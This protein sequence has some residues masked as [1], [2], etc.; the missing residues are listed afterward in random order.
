[1]LSR[2]WIEV[3]LGALVRNASALA[4]HAGVPIIPMIKADA[5]GLGAVP[6]AHALEHLS[7]LAYGVAT[8]EEGAELRGAGIS[9]EIIIFTPLLEDDFARACELNITPTLGSNHEISAWRVYGTPYY[10]S[11]DTGMHRAGVPWREVSSLA[12]ALSANPP[13]GAFT[14]FHSPELDDPTMAQQLGRFEH[15]LKELPEIPAYIHTDSSAAIV[16]HSR[17]SRSGVRPG[18]FMY[19]V[20]S[21]E[22]AQLQPEPVVYMRGRIVE[23]R[24]VEAGDTVSYD[25]TWT[26]ERPT[27]IATVPLGY[28]DGY[29]RNASNRGAAV[30]REKVAPIRGRVTM[31]MTMIDVTDLGAD[32]GD[33]VTMIGDPAAAG[34]GID[35][36]SV[37]ALAD[38]SPYELL[39][40]LRN[41]IKRIYRGQ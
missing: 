11:I 8:V 13:K 38:M 32:V 23:I 2:A 12:P 10:L 33:V 34:T 27:L 7:P 30:V 29:P 1:M 35:V 31:D 17:S 19:G 39:T 26:A 16:R 40:G 5:Y 21:G 9:R 15:A 41:R 25:A 36:A 24:N 20:G 4:R 18:I 6:V 3:D 28:A 37:A 22:G 14:H